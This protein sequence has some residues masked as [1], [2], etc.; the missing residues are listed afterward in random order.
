MRISIKEVLKY[1]NRQGIIKSWEATPD[2]DKRF[3][4]EFY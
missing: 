4:I 1:L 3:I 2:N